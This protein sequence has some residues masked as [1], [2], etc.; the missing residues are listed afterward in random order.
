MNL[1][2]I[3]NPLYEN[4]LKLCHWIDAK[5]YSSSSEILTSCKRETDNLLAMQ[6]ETSRT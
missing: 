1:V 5:Y 3:Y 4:A 2:V 6:N